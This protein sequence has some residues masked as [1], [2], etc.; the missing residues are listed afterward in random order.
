MKKL[1]ILLIASHVGFAQETKRKLVWEE[2]FS[3]KALNEKNWNFELG[4]GCPNCGWGNNERQ[5]YTKENHQLTDGK[6][7][8]T[9]KKDGEKYSSTRITT[10]GKKEFQY[11]RIEARA[12]VPVGKGIWPAFWMLGSN[13]KS[14]GWPKCGE[15]DILE[16]IGREPDMVYT[17]LHTQDTHGEHASSQKTKIDTVE[18]GFHVYA[19][20]WDAEKITFYVDDKLVYTYQPENKTEGNWPFNQPFYI[21]INC[22]IGGNFGGPAV[23]DSIFPQEFIIDYVKV[24]Q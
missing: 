15:I 14:V 8:I 13:I 17:T 2:N 7:V 16:Y 23:D 10:Q 9:A 22:A 24:F 4:D 21:I 18:E 19:T 6:L 5:L 11:G 20:E 12:K 3:G 1:L